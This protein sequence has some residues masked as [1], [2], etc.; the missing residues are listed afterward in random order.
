MRAKPVCYF[1][2]LDR[3]RIALAA[4]APV[5]VYT[6]AAAVRMTAPGNPAA[7]IATGHTPVGNATT[8]NPRQTCSAKVTS[9]T[10]WHSAKASTDESPRPTWNAAGIRAALTRAIEAQSHHDL[11]SADSDI[12]DR[13]C[14]CIAADNRRR[15]KRMA[16]VDVLPRAPPRVVRLP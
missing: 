7:S 8:A 2:C 13:S 11:Q 15:H 4:R 14:S 6:V 1:F 3:F 16:A 5:A 9:E 12:E 10:R